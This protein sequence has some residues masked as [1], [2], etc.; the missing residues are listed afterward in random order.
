MKFRD[1]FHRPELIEAATWTAAFEYAPCA[2]HF[3]S[4]QRHRLLE[5]ARR[6]LLSKTITGAAGLKPDGLMCAAI[7]VKACVPV[8]NLGIEFYSS[9]HSIVV[10]PDEF[11]APEHYVDEDGVMHE[12][13]RELCG[14]SLSDGPMVVSWA[15]IADDRDGACGDL[16]IHE[17]A[18]K[19]DILNGAADGFPPL[20]PDMAP[21]AWTAAFESAYRALANDVD[22]GR[23]TDLDP[24][25]ATDPA[26]FFAVASETFF[27]D[28]KLLARAAPAVYAQL[29]AFYRQDPLP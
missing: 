4:D 5:L 8:L 9:W 13:V 28:P 25:A 14:E 18:H 15:A 3:D 17:C 11:R 1:F 22:A 24:Y 19:L 12:N 23:D 27:T 21:T 10:Y 6:F 16:V 26:E 7:A 2:A 29:K 20:H